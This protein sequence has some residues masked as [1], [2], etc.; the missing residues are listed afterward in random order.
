MNELLK[1][2][3]VNRELEGFESLMSEEELKA[4][5]DLES[6][7]RKFAEVFNTRVDELRKADKDCT[8]MQIAC[9]Q[10]YSD[11]AHETVEKVVMLS[12]FNS[13]GVKAIAEVKV[14]KRFSWEKMLFT[15]LFNKKMNDKD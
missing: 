11:L 6:A 9:F 4:V 8:P 10:V 14:E 3:Q 1:K 7:A 12:S 13:V 2:E 5:S 15:L